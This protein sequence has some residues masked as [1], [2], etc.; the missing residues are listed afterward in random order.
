VQGIEPSDPQQIQPWLRITTTFKANDWW[1]DI[2]LENIVKVVI[3][4]GIVTTIAIVVLTMAP[5]RDYMS[6]NN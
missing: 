5:F 6:T 1:M 3:P 2:W 4:V